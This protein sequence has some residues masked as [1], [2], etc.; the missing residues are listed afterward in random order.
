MYVIAPLLRFAGNTPE[1]VQLASTL[2]GIATLVPLYVLARVMFGRRIAML[3]LAFFAVSGWHG[4]FS[5]VGWRVI[6]VPPFEILALYGAW[7]AL[8]TQ[9]IRHWV[10]AGAGS[11]LSIYTYNSARIV[12]FMVAAFYLLFFPRDRPQWRLHLRGGLIALVTFLV[13]GGPMLWY[14]VHHFPEFQGRAEFLLQ[15]REQE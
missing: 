2:C 14:A 9:W 1:A 13:V 3:G 4:V 10:L 11:A 8:R 5:R 12:P 6:T 7:R 15:R